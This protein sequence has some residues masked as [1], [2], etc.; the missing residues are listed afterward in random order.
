MESVIKPKKLSVHGSLIGSWLNQWRHKYIIY[1]F[2]KYKIIFKIYN[3]IFIMLF[4]HFYIV[5]S[6]V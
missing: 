3:L 2:K 5:E 1:I 6:I 4:T